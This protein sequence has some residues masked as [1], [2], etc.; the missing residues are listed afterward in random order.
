MKYKVLYQNNLFYPMVKETSNYLDILSG[1][2]KEYS[3]KLIM[4]KI[5]LKQTKD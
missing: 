3:K 5:L 4:L 2:E 1:S